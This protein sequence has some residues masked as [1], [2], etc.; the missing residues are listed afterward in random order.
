MGFGPDSA[1]L[2]GLF[3]SR[4]SWWVGQRWI[5]LSGWADCPRL[6]SYWYLALH[7][8]VCLRI[9][10]GQKKAR[11]LLIKGV[12]PFPPLHRS[13]FCCPYVYVFL[14]DITLF[15]GPTLSN[16]NLLA[17]EIRDASR[18]LPLGMVWTLVL[19]GAT[20]LVMVIT[21]AFAVGNVD[22]ILQESQGFPFITVFLNATG[23]VKATTGMTII[24]MILQ[25]CATISNVA[26]T[27]RQLYA[28][29][30][31]EGLPFPSF[32]SRVSTMGKKDTIPPFMPNS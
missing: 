4:G 17:E 9:D 5:V 14:V 26:T 21:F 30:R 13:R 32:L 20:G 25:F 10:Y 22:L 23:S 19:N 6:R 31:D 28:F 24:I 2:R 8:F 3:R 15:H 29:A 11:T 12:S 1:G 7:V 27:S 18:T 16:D